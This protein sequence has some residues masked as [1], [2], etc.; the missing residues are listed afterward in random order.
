MRN[1]DLIL[2]LTKMQPDE[3]KQFIL[4]LRQKRLNYQPNSKIPEA[5]KKKEISDK[6][7]NLLDGMSEDEKQNLLQSLGE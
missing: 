7:I 6:L 4:D 2:P 3:L 5:R 1:E